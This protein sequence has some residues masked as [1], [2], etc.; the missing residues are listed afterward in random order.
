MDKATID[1][2]PEAVLV[3]FSSSFCGVPPAELNLATLQHQEEDNVDVYFIC[4]GLVVSV[5]YLLCYYDYH[6][7]PILW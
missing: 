4:C 5:L 3:D 7:T 2:I 1:A 6:D